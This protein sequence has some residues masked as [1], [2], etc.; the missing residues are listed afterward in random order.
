MVVN[1]IHQLLTMIIDIINIFD[2]ERR[3]RE[4]MQ[5]YKNI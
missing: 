2:C 3:R 1:C 4:T 5:N